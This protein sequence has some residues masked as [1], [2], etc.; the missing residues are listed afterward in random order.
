[1]TFRERFEEKFGT[2]AYA[3]EDEWMR[4]II[5][6]ASLIMALW[7]Y[8]EGL[9]RGKEI[10][11]AVSHKADWADSH[12]AVNKSMFIKILE[13]GFGLVQIK[14]MEAPNCCSKPMHLTRPEALTGKSEKESEV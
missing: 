4:A 6:E 3:D 7:A 10:A 9:K 8:K 2:T 12:D 13:Y 1:M 11:D 5:K 14:Q